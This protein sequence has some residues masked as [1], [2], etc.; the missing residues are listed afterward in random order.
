M[1]ELFVSRSGEI[2]S[3]KM[4]PFQTAGVGRIFI[5]FVHDAF[6][7]YILS[8]QGVKELDAAVIMRKF[9]ELMSDEEFVRIVQPPFTL[10]IDFADDL[11]EELNLIVEPFNGQ[12]VYNPKFVEEHMLP[13]L[14]SLLEMMARGGG[15]DGR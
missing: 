15:D 10:V 9:Y 11:L 2:L 13:D 14:S 1:H 8:T 5:L 12:V 4:L 7:S 6:S 3:V